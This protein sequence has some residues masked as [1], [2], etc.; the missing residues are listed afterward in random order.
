MYGRGSSFRT[1]LGQSAR[2]AVD[3]VRINGRHVSMKF[4]EPVTTSRD[5]TI[6]FTLSLILLCISSRVSIST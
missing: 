4:C 6:G 2:P 3:I 5:I 1:H